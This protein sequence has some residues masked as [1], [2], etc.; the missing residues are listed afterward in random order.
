MRST[1]K[2]GDDS[3]MVWACFTA[4]VVG[5]IHII[6]GKMNAVMYCWILDTHLHPTVKIIF[7]NRIT[8]RSIPV[9]MKKRVYGGQKINVLEWISR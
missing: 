1:V 6:D 9:S 5:N 3:N 8:I 4:E 2:H 7:F